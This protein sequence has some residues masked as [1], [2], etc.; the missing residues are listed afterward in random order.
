MLTMFKVAL[1]EGWLDI[2]FWGTDS[3]GPGKMFERD[4]QLGWALFFAFFI[5]V[6]AFFT[7]N[8]FDGVVID[9]F[10]TC[11]EESLGL[12][13]FN[14]SQSKWIKLQATVALVKPKIEALEPPE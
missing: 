2:M 5:A 9:N 7:L 3:P 13:E 10:D 8:L 12:S 6:G 1:T 11:T 14:P 4:Y